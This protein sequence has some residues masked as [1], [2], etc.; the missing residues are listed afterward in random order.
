MRVPYAAPGA[1][2]RG[3]EHTKNTYRRHLTLDLL[4]PSP[5]NFLDVG[6]HGSRT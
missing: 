5:P 1:E 3:G 4:R 2:K 6:R